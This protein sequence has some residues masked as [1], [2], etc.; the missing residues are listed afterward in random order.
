MKKYI[1][2]ISTALILLA[3][4]GC[5]PIA[6]A[7][8][9]WYKTGMTDD[10]M[11]RDMMTCR[12][13]GMQSAQTN[14]VAG[15]LFV[16]GWIQQEANECMVGLGYSQGGYSSSSSKGD[17]DA[18]GEIEKQK[19]LL[20]AN[21]EF[22]SYFSKTACSP[23][24]ITMQQMVDKSKITAAQQPVLLQVRKAEDALSK[25]E[26]TKF[27]LMGSSGVKIADFYQSDVAPQIEKNT[28]DL[29]GGSITWGEYNRRRKYIWTNTNSAI[30]KIQ[31]N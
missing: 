9:N 7:P 17:I 21:P 29:Y 30:K 20:C 3:L 11:R 24:E 13:Y 12:Q 27:R 16:E 18:I 5:L 14:G 31:T 2:S 15:N 10:Q 6:Q 19:K 1:S 26:R 23:S 25:S 8:K 22:K 4:N 28:L